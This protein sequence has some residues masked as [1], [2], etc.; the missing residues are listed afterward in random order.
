VISAAVKR[1]VFFGVFASIFCCGLS[2]CADPSKLPT[3]SATFVSAGLESSP[4]YTLEVCSTDRE[5]ALGL[6]YR[7][8]LPELSGMLFVFPLERQ[9]AFWMKNTYIPLD[10]VFLDQEM[11][12]VGILE[13]VPPLTEA[14]RS[15]GK[16]SKFVVEFGAGVTRKHGLT[17]GARM[18]VDGVIPSAQ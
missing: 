9:N 15:V 11:K 16:P 12:V 13:N 7:R 6:M 14:P 10:M 3:V 17:E 1:L 18:V 8:S 2:A 5:R 4:K